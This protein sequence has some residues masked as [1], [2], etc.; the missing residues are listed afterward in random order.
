[1]SDLQSIQPHPIKVTDSVSNS[2]MAD[3]KALENA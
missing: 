1:M 3:V 2:D